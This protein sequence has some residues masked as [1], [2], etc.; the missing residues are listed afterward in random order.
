MDEQ[1][2]NT[3][4][5]EETD[6]FSEE[7]LAAFEDGW[8]DAPTPV[9]EE[10]EPEEPEADEPEEQEQ[11][12]EAEETETAEE[13]GGDGTDDGEPA[14]TKTDEPEKFQLTHLKE[15]KDYTRDETIALAQ[16]GLD[17]D[18]IRGERDKLR[19][20]KAELEQYGAFVKEM[21]ENAGLTPEGLM[22]STRVRLAMNKAKAEGK[23]VSEDQVRDRIRQ[24]QR[25]AAAPKEE[26]KEETKPDDGE[27]KAKMAIDRF[28]QLYPD[29]KGDEIPQKVWDE[30]N[31]LGDLVVP[32]Q[33]YQNEK[34]REELATLKQNQKNRERS[35]GSRRTAGA[36]V[37]RD[38]FDEGWD[39]SS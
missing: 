13:T 2:T 1:I 3:E 19:T 20:E 22:E 10:T 17:Y 12:E 25:E 28:M 15:T 4:A 34:L 7:E 31:K 37:T 6:G 8:G 21:A 26:P 39:S 27:A 35:T 32:W 38:A 23:T 33:K 11:G 30:A 5:V 18:Y 29:V 14:D 16:K 9:T 36:S 24:A